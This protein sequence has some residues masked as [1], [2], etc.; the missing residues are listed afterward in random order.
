MPI[1]QTLNSRSLVTGDGEALLSPQAAAASEANPAAWCP[2]TLAGC[3]CPGEDTA[4][5]P[6]C[7]SGGGRSSDAEQAGRHYQNRAY[8]QSEDPKNSVVHIKV[9]SLLSTNW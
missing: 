1:L 5:V 7:K 9:F 4:M 2:V 6:Q 8:T 3:L